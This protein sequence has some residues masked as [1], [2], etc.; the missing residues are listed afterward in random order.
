MTLVD[1][2]ESELAN[3]GAPHGGTAS[4]RNFRECQGMVRCYR[5]Q[6][7]YKIHELSARTRSGLLQVDS[8]LFKL[9]ARASSPSDRKTHPLESFLRTRE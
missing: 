3:K 5:E 2:P 1:D 6:P 4:P 8:A 7:L 9:A